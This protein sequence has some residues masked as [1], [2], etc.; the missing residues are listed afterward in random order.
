MFKRLLLILAALAGSFPVC[1]SPAHARDL[2]FEE[3]VRAQEAIERV[4][5]SHRIGA[6]APFE[7]A[8]P[9][10]PIEEKVRRYLTQSTALEQSRGIR[11]TAESLRRE[12]ERIARQTRFPERLRQIYLA[13]GEDPVLVQ[14]CFVRPV[15]VE[16]LARSHFAG[17]DWKEL[18]DDRDEYRITTVARADEALPGPSVDTVDCFPDDTWRHGHSAVWTGTLTA[19]IPIR[20]LV[21]ARSR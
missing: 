4:Y 14:E 2:T 3:R 7:Q 17:D 9:R 10:Q 1:V 18:R 11:I 16:R 15:I 8:V 5:Y 21:P 19:T 12:L 6:E 20:S 13:L